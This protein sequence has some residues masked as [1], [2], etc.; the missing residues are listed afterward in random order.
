MSR[1]DLMGECRCKIKG[2]RFRLPT[3]ELLGWRLGRT[4]FVDRGLERARNRC[5]DGVD[6]LGRDLR[7]LGRVVG[8]FDIGL[9]VGIVLVDVGFVGWSVVV[10]VDLIVSVAVAVVAA[11]DV[12]VVVVAGVV[13][14]DEEV[15]DF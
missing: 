6:L 11:V 5:C 9:G 1:R 7:D 10:E 12:V 3:T 14:V 2:N 15:V 8:R 4:L 13:V